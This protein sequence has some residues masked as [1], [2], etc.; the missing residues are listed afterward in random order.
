VFLAGTNAITLD[1]RLVNVDAAGNR[2]A[3]M[4][5]GHPKSIVVVGRNK[6]VNNLDEAFNRIRNVIAPNHMWIRAVELGGDRT[7]TP[8]VATGACSDCRSKDRMCNV[9][10]II[11]GKPLR[12]DISIVIVDED[13]G[14]AWD[15]S[16]P[17]ERIDRIKEEYKKFVWIPPR[18]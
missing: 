18:K 14:L 9:F 2:V 10:T 15:E 6:L 17:R 12:T 7:E 3:G 4:F 1:G 13:L 11:E 8:C 16:W 5:H